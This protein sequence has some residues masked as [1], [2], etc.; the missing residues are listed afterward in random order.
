VP[1]AAQPDRR[2]AARGRA[3]G[4]L[5]GISFRVGFLR[6]DGADDA[7]T[8]LSLAAEHAAHVAEVAGIDAVALGS[9]FD[10]ATMGARDDVV[11]GRVK[12]SRRLRQRRH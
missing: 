11:R 2:P 12:R 3:S 4:G 10:G 1:V 5:V 8:P 6:A 9:D 7:D